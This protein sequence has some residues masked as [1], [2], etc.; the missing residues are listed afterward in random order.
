MIAEIVYL[1]PRFYVPCSVLAF[2]VFST[3]RRHVALVL[4]DLPMPCLTVQSYARCAK[5]RTLLSRHVILRDD[6][7]C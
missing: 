5:L 1:L 4:F 3:Y 2:Y 7:T 6:V